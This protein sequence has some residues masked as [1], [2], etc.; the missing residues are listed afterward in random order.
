MASARISKAQIRPQDRQRFAERKSC[1]CQKAKCWRRNAEPRR[2]GL[3]H[4]VSYDELISGARLS[5]GEH[6]IF[7]SSIAD[8]NVLYEAY[9]ASMKGSAWK[10]EP[11]RFEINFLSEII[12]LKKEIENRTYQT[13]EGSTFIY[14]ERGKTRLIHGGRMRDRVIRHALCDNELTGKL[15]PYLIHNNGASQKGKGMSF[16][17]N[18]FEK[19]LH[20]YWLEHRS[21]D[22]YIGFVDISKFYDNMQHD[23]IIESV[24]PKLEKDAAW[25]LVEILKTFEID[26]SYMSDDKYASCLSAKFDSIKYHTEIPDESKTGEKMMRKSVDIGDQ[27]SQN[28][29]IYFPTRLDN[30]AKIVRGC[31]HYGRYMDDIYIICES[32]EEV[33]SIID[34]ITEQAKELGMFINEKK[35]RIEKL[36]GN[37]KYLQ[38]R[39]TLTDT[40]RVIRRINPKN[41]TR[42]RRKLKAYKRLL[43]K[44]AMPMEDIEEAFK[45]WLGASFKYMSNQQIINMISLYMNLFR[46]KPTWKKQSQLRWLTAQC[47]KISA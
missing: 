9:R 4:A 29:G 38:I 12:K 17:R 32:K 13:A 36:S 19:D 44:G 7:M 16:A 5:Q 23:K 20:N 25:L 2:V 41:V 39:Y 46:R 18:Q 28:I 42:E 34:G 37:Y 47:S 40:G 45:S 11:Q 30:Y 1:P 31:K 15:N 6:G 21:N 10:E 43:D 14:R 27:V 33:Q 26:V 8:L 35:T 22:G 3:L 24:C